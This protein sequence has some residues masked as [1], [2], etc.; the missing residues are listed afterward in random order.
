MTSLTPAD[1]ATGYDTVI[2]AG[3]DMQGRLFGKRMPVRRFLR[4]VDEGI[5]VC[6]CVYA[7][8]IEEDL[9]GA[10]VDYTG[11]HTG[12]HD[13]QLVPDLATLRKAAWLPGT[14][15]VLGDSVAEDTGEPV[16][17]SPRAVLRRQCDV[18]A[19][20]GRAATAA[21]ELEFHLYRGTPEQLRTG[22]YRDLD[23]TTQ[24]RADYLITEG[25]AL[26]EFFRPLRD[27][28]E[29]SDIPVEVA[30]V[31]YGLGQWEINLEYTDPL[32]MADR[33]VLFKSAVKHLATRAGMTATFMP[34][35][36][37][38]G[39]G[40][41]C[42]IHTALTGDGEPVFYDAAAPHTASRTLLAAVAGILDHAAELMV[43]YA[44]TVNAGR[45]ILSEDFA[46][47]GTTWGYDNR[48]TTC[49][50]LGKSPSANRVETRLPGSDVNPYLGIAAVL[51]S[52][53]DGIG[54]DLDPGA[55]FTGNAYAQ[56]TVGTLPET[57]GE[58]ARLFAASE[59]A[60]AAF[61]KDVVDHY[62]TF[63]THEWRTFLRAVSDFDR[64][65]Y[66]ERS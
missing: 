16:A 50:V 59:F 52:M 6:S 23:P 25:D 57:L 27:C 45:R 42:H 22:G 32:E 19:K 65:R 7:W 55:P 20:E 46:G 26:E 38:E 63:A 2:V 31:E 33:H 48:T 10:Q 35:P 8:D 30:Q 47:N 60:T 51:A 14:A 28:L 11:F 17:V 34:R 3:V 29:A 13:F 58:A 21:T 44:P 56:D 41:S 24:A 66:L 61:G 1:L 4:V 9:G 43:W 12:W 15:I 39:M 53:R 54:R 37:T 18:L 36:L 5:H 49:R 62:A 64:Q 40:S